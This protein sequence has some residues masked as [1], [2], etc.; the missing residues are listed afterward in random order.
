MYDITDDHY[1]NVQ[2]APVNGQTYTVYSGN[3]N[4]YL[5]SGGI[6]NALYSYYSAN[7]VGASSLEGTISLN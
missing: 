4:F 6:W 5:N 1:Y 2:S 3:S 7:I